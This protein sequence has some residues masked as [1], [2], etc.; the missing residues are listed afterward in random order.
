MSRKSF[1]LSFVIHFFTVT[2]TSIIRTTTAG[3]IA[4]EMLIATSIPPYG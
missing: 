1:R 4:K 3:S 2:T